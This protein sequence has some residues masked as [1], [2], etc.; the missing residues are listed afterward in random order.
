MHYYIKKP[1]GFNVAYT[2]KYCKKLKLYRPLS[3]FW[4]ALISISAIPE[5]NAILN[6][7]LERVDLVNMT[8]EADPFRGGIV[9]PR[10]ISSSTS[11][12]ESFEHRVMQAL[13]FIDDNSQIGNRMLNDLAWKTAR[14]VDGYSVQ[15][16]DGNLFNGGNTYIDYVEGNQGMSYPLS[17]FTARRSGLSYSSTSNSGSDSLILLDFYR[18]RLDTHLMVHELSHSYGFGLG[19]G[20]PLAL[21]PNDPVMTSHFFTQGPLTGMSLGG[22]KEEYENM[23]LTVNPKRNGVSE[24]TIMQEIYSSTKKSK[25]KPILG[26]RNI[27]SNEI[28]SSSVFLQSII[29]Q[30]PIKKKRNRS[31]YADSWYDETKNSIYTVKPAPENPSPTPVK[32]SLSDIFSKMQFGR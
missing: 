7:E 13:D 20:V 24:R 18:K 1:Y 27:T 12:A 15:I 17:P 14:S 32:D 16:S 10:L 2:K 30:W 5:P 25:H 11:R 9:I 6:E 4:I 23:G 8:L 29:T 21:D 28:I 26:Y 3:F 22:A 19:F 31:L